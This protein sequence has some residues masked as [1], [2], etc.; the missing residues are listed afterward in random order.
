MKN[1]IKNKMKRKLI[2]SL[3]VLL[4]PLILVS[5]P[6][7]F[8]L[9]QTG[10]ILPSAEA[11]TA[12]EYKEISGLT[13]IDWADMIVYDT[14]RYDNDFSLAVPSDTAF[15]FLIVNYKR[16][17]ERRRCIKRNAEGKCI[18]YETYWEVAEE[19]TLSGK[20]EILNLLENLNYNTSEWT[21]KEAFT[22]LKSLDEREE[23]IIEFMYRDIEDMM[24]MGNFDKQ[25]TEWVDTLISEGIIYELYGEFFDLPEHITPV[26]DSFFMWPTPDLH[27][28]TSP[29]GWRIHPVTGKRSFH[30]GV[31]ISG[32]NAMGKPIVSVADG[33]VIQV[34]LTPDNAAGNNVRIKHTDRE[35]REWQSRYCHMSRISVSVGQQVLQGD[36]IGAVGSTGRSTGAHLHFELKF[37]GQLVNGALYLPQ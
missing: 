19:K 2:L 27:T 1:R 12:E 4:L 33:T 14:V 5:C 20:D 21:I 8:F 17:V 34:N 36:V 26:G 15:E 32:A 30:S 35:G 22:T 6:I 29:F 11:A 24:I 23:Y 3:I 7:M 13:G 16:R 25:Q 37:E 18:E 10:M 31:D 28:I 9:V